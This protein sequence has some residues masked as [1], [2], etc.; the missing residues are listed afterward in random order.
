[1]KIELE[2]KD[3]EAI[4][5]RVAELL[6]PQS[7]RKT[8][9]SEDDGIYDVKVLAAY[10]KVKPRWVY[11]R[12]SENAIPFIRVGRYIRFSKTSIDEWLTMK[13]LKPLP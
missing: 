9:E 8:T 12:V 4:A 13:A 5:Q 6:L 7:T 1:M 11:D 2:H 3:I 10:I